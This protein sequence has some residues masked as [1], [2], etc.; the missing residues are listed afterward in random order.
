MKLRTFVL[1]AVLLIV[2]A[3]APVASGQTVTM[4]PYVVQPGDTLSKIASQ[5]CTT[6][7]EVYQ[8]NAAVIGPNPDVLRPGTVL[9]VPNRCTT[10]G[11]GVY[12]R[13]PSMYANGAVTGNVY[14]VAPGDTWYS[15]G[16]RFGLPWEQISA[17]NGG[18]SLYP[19][20]QLI[21]PGLSGTPPPA[22]K[23]YIS[24]TNP[25]AGA[26][27]PATFT[28]SGMGAG[29]PEGNVVVTAKDSAGRVL[30]QKATVLQGANVGLGGEGA[31]STTMTVNTGNIMPGAIEATSPGAAAMA[32]VSI[33][34]SGAGSGGGGNSTG[35]VYAP[36][37][38]TITAAPGA[39]MYQY[40]GGPMTGQFVS[41]GQFEAKQRTVYNNMDWYMIQPEASM[42]NPPMWVPVSSLSGVGQ[43]CR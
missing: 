13:G 18:G 34:Y 39:P 20:R 41:G 11:S 21:I 8:I 27:L 2:V 7:E 17:A 24:I 15:I 28:V 12:D 6:W 9:Y 37:E 30:A 25:Q 16:Q 10:S 32:A 14:T 26:S 33:T 42:G 23:T 43:G 4:A 19:G 29:L 31:W 1:L 22:Q 36:G 5:Y 40:P 3:L 38:C 35:V